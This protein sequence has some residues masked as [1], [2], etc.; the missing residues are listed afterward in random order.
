[1]P[2]PT[3]RHSYN[4]QKRV[5]ENKYPVGTLVVI[6]TRRAE[7]MDSKTHV[8]VVTN[9]SVLR[10]PNSWIDSTTES[11]ED[12]EGPRVHCSTNHPEHEDVRHL[13]SHELSLVGAYK[14]DEIVGMFE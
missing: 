3:R 4:R 14:Q 5:L 2:E 9:H 12:F 6:E 8:A 13:N 7:H 11:I 1:M 10:F